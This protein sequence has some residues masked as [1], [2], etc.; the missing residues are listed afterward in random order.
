MSLTSAER[1]VLRARANA[2]KSQ[3]SVGRE[4]LTPAV[5]EAIRSALRRNDLIKVRIRAADHAEADEVARQ[6]VEAV[7]CDLV[8]RTGRV[9]VLYSPAGALDGE[10]ERGPE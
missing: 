3:M 6:I 10:D 5:I 9:A 2:I 7:P 4:G 8:A 1:Q